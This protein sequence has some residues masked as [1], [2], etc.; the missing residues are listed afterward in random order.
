ME[1]TCTELFRMIMRINRIHH[2][3][4]TN[5]VSKLGIHPSEHFL[6]MQLDHIGEAASQSQIAC[7]MDI[8]PASVAR[9]IKSLNNGGY[10]EK[11]EC[12]GDSRRN[13][14][15]ITAKGK[16]VTEESRRMFS[17]TDEKLFEGFSEE[18]LKR[19]RGF[20]ERMLENIS[21]Y[22]QSKKA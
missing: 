6:L 4:N 8:T 15:R 1:G 11:N 10:I 2:R 12:E 5:S 20:L 18:E 19:M 13:E 21:A 7:M 16:A 9:T 14:I 22:E 3:V 17:I